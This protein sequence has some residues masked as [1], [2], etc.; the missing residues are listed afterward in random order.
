MDK[1]VEKAIRTRGY[2]PAGE[3]TDS[4]FEKVTSLE[5]SDTPITEELEKPKGELTEEDL[6]WITD[7]DLAGTK[8]T[9]A[10]LKDVAKLKSLERISLYVDGTKVTDAGVS[11]LSKALPN[12]EIHRYLSSP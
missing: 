9:D 2:N 12:C 3:L 8:I 6:L 11:E 1:I 10:G 7:L 5:L 4:D